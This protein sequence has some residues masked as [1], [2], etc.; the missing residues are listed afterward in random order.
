MRPW[1]VRTPSEQLPKRAACRAATTATSGGLAQARV[2]KYGCLSVWTSECIFT[3]RK[4]AG[5]L[6]FFLWSECVR[7]LQEPLWQTHSVA[8]FWVRLESADA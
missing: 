4:P 7:L 5:A 6:R 1:Y 3:E 2:D 8:V